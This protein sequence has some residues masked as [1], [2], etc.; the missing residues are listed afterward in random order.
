[1]ATNH[2]SRR[3]HAF[4]AALQPVSAAFSVPSSGCGG[5]NNNPL[6]GGGRPSPQ[7]FVDLNNF[8]CEEFARHGLKRPAPPSP[9]HTDE[10][11]DSPTHKKPRFM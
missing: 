5:G 8:V 9:T 4:G 6:G 3:G 11:M 2:Q 10:V 1:V 7:H